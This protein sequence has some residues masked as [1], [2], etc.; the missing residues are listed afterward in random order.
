[1]Q[2]KV[3]ALQSADF[4]LTIIFLYQSRIFKGLGKVLYLREKSQICAQNVKQLY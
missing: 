2:I 4:K 3:Q 1:M